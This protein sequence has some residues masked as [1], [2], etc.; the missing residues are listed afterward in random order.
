MYATSTKKSKLLTD[1]HAPHHKPTAPHGG[2]SYAFT[3]RSDCT[4]TPRCELRTTSP[5]RVASRN[6]V[7]GCLTA[8][9]TQ[10]GSVAVS[11]PK[12]IQK[13]RG[14][15]GCGEVGGVS[16]RPPH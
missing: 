1:Q 16:P 6:F 15:E 12:E 13:D 14:Q 11:A 7:T 8:D 5:R 10:G 3:G 2:F 4:N 9:V